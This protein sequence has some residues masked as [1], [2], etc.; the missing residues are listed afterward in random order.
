MRRRRSP[1]PELNKEILA[2][3][4]GTAGITAF[5]YSATD[6]FAKDP[7]RKLDDFK[8]KK[9]RINATPAEAP[10]HRGARRHRGAAAYQRG[11]PCPATRRHHGTQ[12][13]SS[14]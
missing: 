4:E 7:I 6:Y 5:V 8:G 10:A 1:I 11:G 14:L 2:L 13:A 12:S 3:G 9:F